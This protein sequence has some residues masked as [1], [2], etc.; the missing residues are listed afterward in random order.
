MLLLVHCDAADTRRTQRTLYIEFDI[1]CP[2]DDI[3]V[4]IAQFVY[5]TMHTTTL[6][7]HTG[8]YRVDTVVETFHGHLGALARHAGYLLDGYQ[9]IVDFRHLGFQE[10]LQEA[11]TGTAEDN[12]RIVVL[13]I[14]P[15]DDGPYSLALAVN[16]CGNL[17]R[18]RQYQLVVLIIHQQHLALP[19]LIDLGRNHLTHL[20][21]IFIIERIVLQFQYLRCQRLTQCKDGTTTELGE[22]DT[23]R[24]LLTHFVVGLYLERILKADLLVFILHLT[25]G[26]YRTVAI[27][28]KVALVGV[29]D[30][31]KVLVTAINLGEYI[32]KTLFQHADQCGAVDILRLLE[33][34]KGVNHTDWLFRCFSCC[35]SFT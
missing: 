5:D 9:A 21:L 13:V 3:D 25:I 4:L 34:F 7:A 19:D 16:V 24:H 17:L 28:F 31:I 15:L 6:H 14:H 23:L 1:G 27:D 35:H 8:T 29:H 10:A 22:I 26:Y 20:V 18:L 30:D 12:F 32:T 33:L 11:G 2:V